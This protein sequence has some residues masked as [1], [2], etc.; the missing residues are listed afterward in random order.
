MLFFRHPRPVIDGRA[1]AVQIAQ[2]KVQASQDN[3]VIIIENKPVAQTTAGHDQ[4][5]P[6]P[7][8]GPA[9]STRRHE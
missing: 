2:R 6:A 3:Q 1:V 4:Q 8:P 5:L 9:S 7:L